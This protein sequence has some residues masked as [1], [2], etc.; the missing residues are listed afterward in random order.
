M[1][2]NVYCPSI[3]LAGYISNDCDKE[4]REWRNWFKENRPG[5]RWLDPTNGEAPETIKNHGLDSKIDAGLIVSRDLTSVKNADI[6]LINTDTFKNKRP[7]T[8]SI[9]EIAWAYL[10]NKPIVMLSKD[11]NYIKHPFMKVMCSSIVQKKEDALKA[12][13][14]IIQGL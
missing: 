8:G 7:I 3:Y 9:V 2:N 6:I 5:Y 12:L 14:F 4:C 1:L 10:L 11:E 13:E